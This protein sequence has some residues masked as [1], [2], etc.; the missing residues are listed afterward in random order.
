MKEW[1]DKLPAAEPLTP[2]EA[3]EL[4][5]L[6]GSAAF[7]KASANI[8]ERADGLREQMMGVNFLGQDGVTK[9]MTLQAQYRA[10]IQLFDDLLTQA[11][12]QETSNDNP[13]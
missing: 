8:I 3:E 7:R 5:S 13:G 9:A 10:C 4:K 11:N 2:Q 6:L 12:P 1:Y